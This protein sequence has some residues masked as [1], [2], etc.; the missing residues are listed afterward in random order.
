MQNMS[1]N[2]GLLL[3]GGNGTRLRPLT[4]TT[5]KHLLP[6][7]NKQMVYY[8]LQTMIE[9]GVKD[10]LVVSGPE[11]AGH[12]LELLGSG[13]S[14]NI[15]LT[16][17]VQDLAG[18][19]AQA[20]ALGKDFIGSNMEPFLVMLGDNIF[21]D[22]LNINLKESTQAKVFLKKVPDAYRFGVPEF[23]YNQKIEFIVEKP[24]DKK[25][26][27]AVTG[28]YIYYRDVFELISRMKPSGRGELEITDVNNYYAKLGILDYDT[29]TG[30]WS[31]AGTFESLHRSN[32]WAKAQE[33]GIK[34]T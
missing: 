1:I 5:N 22:K 6:V 3:C 11:H 20:L 34:T 26:G 14:F 4:L 15:N 28:A 32:N 17:K 19:I 8:P 21:E 25:N 2:K 7:H 23:D 29:L 9:A 18:G 30:F 12:F 33:N 10:I 27:Y 16:Y 31:D 24:K 13:S